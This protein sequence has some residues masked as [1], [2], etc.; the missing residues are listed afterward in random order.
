MDKSV[1]VNKI[2]WILRTDITL[3]KSISFRVITLTFH[4]KQLFSPY[5]YFICTHKFNSNCTVKY[6]ISNNLMDF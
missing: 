5:L 3:S 4:L 6:T 1:L 2:I